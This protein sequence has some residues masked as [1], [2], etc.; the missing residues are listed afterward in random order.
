MKTTAIA[1]ATMFFGALAGQADA[2]GEKKTTCDHT[3]GLCIQVGERT[4]SKKVRAII[5]Y[6]TETTYRNETRVRTVTHY[7]NETR[8]RNVTRYRTGWKTRT[9]RTYRI[10][11]VRVMAGT[12]H[13]GRPVYRIVQRRVP[14]NTTQRYQVRVPYQVREAYIVQVP[15]R[16]QERYTVRVPVTKRVPIYG[17]KRVTETEPNYLCFDW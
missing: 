7:N 16:E 4:V 12:D 6:R 5:G 15:C 9:V 11:R 3:T 8:Y 17:F 10:E 1:L 2:H 14:C 13:C